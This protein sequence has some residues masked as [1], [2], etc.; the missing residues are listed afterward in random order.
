[1]KNQDWPKKLQFICSNTVKNTFEKWKMKNV[2]FLNVFDINKT[3]KRKNYYLFTS[4][5]DWSLSNKCRHW[6]SW[7][8][9]WWSK[10]TTCSNMWHMPKVSYKTVRW[11]RIKERIPATQISSGANDLFVWHEIFYKYF[12]MK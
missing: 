11:T 8:C 10:S 3:F 12:Q 1:M 2:K 4:Y 6:N 7:S 9:Q 5:Y